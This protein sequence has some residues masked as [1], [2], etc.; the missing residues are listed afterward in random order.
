MEG[1]HQ[2]DAGGSSGVWIEMKRVRKAVSAAGSPAPVP[3][4]SFDQPHDYVLI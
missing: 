3:E 2:G 1:G 4:D